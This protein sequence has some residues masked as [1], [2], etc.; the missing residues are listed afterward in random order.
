M[1]DYTL[2]ELP[3]NIVI[4]DCPE[5][6][7]TNNSEGLKKIL[8]SCIEREIYRI[9]INLSGTAYV[10]SS[11]LGAIVSRIAAARSQGGAIK[12]V[13]SSPLVIQLL[14]VTNLNKILNCFDDLD[15]AVNS[16]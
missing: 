4:I 16:F 5:R 8:T 6:L 7:E 3:G 12:L 9:V 14:E 1:I 10:D 11:G 13:V 2:H 15:A